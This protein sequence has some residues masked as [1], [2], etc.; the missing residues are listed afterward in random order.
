[1]D[2]T[3]I[4]SFIGNA[5]LGIIAFFSVMFYKKVDQIADDLN[6]VKTQWAVYG[7]RMNG[8]ERRVTTLETT[9]KIKQPTP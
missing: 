6:L 5:L 3:K 9:Q 4:F 1:M 8:L 7:E 2:T